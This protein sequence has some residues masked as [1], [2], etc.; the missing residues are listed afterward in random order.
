[1]ESISQPD[2]T[3]ANHLVCRLVLLS[4]VPTVAAP[5]T[6]NMSTPPSPRALSNPAAS[7]L[8][9]AEGHQLRPEQGRRVRGLRSL[10]EEEAPPKERRAMRPLAR[11]RASWRSTA[12]EKKM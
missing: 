6:S 3:K 9:G 11:P 7:R 8:C 1:M 5:S 4:T 12:S 10:D 2:E